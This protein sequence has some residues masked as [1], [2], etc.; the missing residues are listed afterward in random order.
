MNAK[1]AL[2]PKSPE[3]IAR[4]KLRDN[5]SLLSTESFKTSAMVYTHGDVALENVIVINS[6]NDIIFRAVGNVQVIKAGLDKPKDQVHAEKD[7]S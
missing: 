1:T 3:E 2:V 7:G 4:E 5:L 6:L